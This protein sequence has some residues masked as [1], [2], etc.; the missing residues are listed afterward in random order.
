MFKNLYK[1]CFEQ[2][3]K[4]FLTLF[5][6]FFLISP[7]FA[8][9]L[10][11]TGKAG[12]YIPVGDWANYHNSSPFISFGTDLIKKDYLN[13]GLA[14][15]VSSFSGKLNNSY[16]LQIFSPGISIEFFP[17]FFIKNYY[18]FINGTLSYNFMERRL[19]NSIEKGRD[20]SILT[21]LGTEIKMSKNWSFA[22]FF[23]EKHFAGGIDMLILGIGLGFNK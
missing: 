16:N 11:F 13:S 15:D 20:F 19:H 21:L 6:I 17:L 8:V 22:P 10:N 4:K 7:L 3:P 5:F 2:L 23:G 1:F 9:T 14:F 12:S 18:L